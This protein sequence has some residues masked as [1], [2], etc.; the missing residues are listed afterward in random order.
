MRSFRG[1]QTNEGRKEKEHRK[2]R[3]HL[4]GKWV[5]KCKVQ[6]MKSYTE[7]SDE[8]HFFDYCE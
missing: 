3:I 6:S 8:R 5:C 4:N 7:N 1:E 2:G